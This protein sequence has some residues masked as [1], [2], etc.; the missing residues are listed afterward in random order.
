[1]SAGS[2]TAAVRAD[3]GRSKGYP[4]GRRVKV[5]RVEAAEGS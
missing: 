2:R 5:Q 1:M 3:E 4:L